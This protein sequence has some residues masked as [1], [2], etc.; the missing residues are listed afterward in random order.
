MITI[1][2]R[3]NM[4]MRHRPTRGQC[5]T[6][7]QC[8]ITRRF[9]QLAVAMLTVCSLTLSPCGTLTASAQDNDISENPTAQNSSGLNTIQ[10][11]KVSNLPD[12]KHII[13]VGLKNTPTVTPLNF[14]IN[15][16]PRIA[17]D[18]VNTGNGLDKS[19][20]E[21]GEGELRSANV[22][23]VGTR[24]R[25][26][27]NL[28]QM[29]AYTSAL[30]GNN[31]IITLQGSTAKTMASASSRFAEAQPSVQK[32]SLNNIDFRRGKN[33]EGRIQVDLSDIGIGIDVRQQG[34][35][36]IVDFNK[37]SLPRNLQRKLD[38]VDFNT[39]VEG[40]DTFT[41]GDNVRMIIEPKG[42]WEHAAYQTDKRFVVEIKPVIEDPKK[43][44][45]GP[46][47]YTGEKLTLSFQNIS[48]R[49]ALNVI[50]DFTDLNMVISDTVSGNLTLRLK[51]VPWDQALQ[52]ILD[53]R[54]LDMRKNGNVVQV[55]PREEINAR[56]KANL[57][58]GQEI[59]DLEILRTESFQ[60]SYQ[61]ADAVATLLQNEKQRILS[62]RGSAIADQRTNTVFIQDTS[63]RLEDAAALIKQI[64]IAVRQVMIEA[65]F[66]D[67]R[68]TFTRNLGGK[69]GFTGPLQQS[70]VPGGFT[71]GT[72]G[73]N[74]ISLP[75]GS[76]GVGGLNLT[77]IGSAGA[78]IL[79]LELSASEIDGDAKS[80]ASP[81]VVTANGTEASVEAGVEI[82]YT[83]FS[84]TAG[85]S[86]AFKKAT[87]SL[88][89]TPQITP[90]NNINMKI[91]ANEDTVGDVFGG[92]PSVNT[93]QISTQVLVDNGGTVVIGG[94]Y[95][96]GQTDSTTKV[97]LLGDIPII[98]WL[99]KQN[100]VT[101]NK[102][103]LLIFISPKILQDSLNLR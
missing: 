27:I 74:N 31:L 23:Q 10:S 52:I 69:I 82:P 11:L 42:N 24:T 22:V 64:D 65:R 41:Q 54:S 36:L 72:G 19:T 70:L 17:F 33:G 44:A 96:Q 97:P 29:L 40:I 57:T 58:V 75:G 95:T 55:A 25:L 26:V 60:L 62:K 84:P 28:S 30:E 21:F 3:P 91:N 43:A 8:K 16:P 50:A 48:V 66:V 68:D 49:E 78:K 37:A 71:S 13:E 34:R 20:L 92:I 101:D 77:L 67:A 46:K 99:F 18:F 2:A 6:G 45:R 89:V 7:G 56:E 9:T 5:P 73:S 14:S 12:G 93:K 90:D 47:E 53:S 94:I 35:K 32:Y 76:S 88:K 79:G 39:P 83:T 4:Q 86:V 102:R 81:R 15:T 1:K 85:S 87:L 51:D 63:A 80:I 59:A 103:E 98:G 61:K 38:V 100:A